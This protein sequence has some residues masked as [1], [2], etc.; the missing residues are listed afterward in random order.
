MSSSMVGMGSLSREGGPGPVLMTP[1]RVNAP[2]FLRKV[3]RAEI[4]F[5]VPRM[6]GSD[7]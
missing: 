4:P 5:R 7:N 1:G 6:V 2:D 3:V